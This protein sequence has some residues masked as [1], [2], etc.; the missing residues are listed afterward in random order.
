METQGSDVCVCGQAG[1]PSCQEKEAHA[2]LD[3]FVEMGGNFIDCADMYQFG[4]SEEIVGRW[5]KKYVPFK[6]GS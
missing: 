5:L 2:I 6:V 4:Q 1:R 3:R